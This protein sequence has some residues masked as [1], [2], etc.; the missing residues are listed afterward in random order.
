MIN[1]LGTD[2]MT[3]K[4]ASQRYGYS[5]SWFQKARYMKKSPAY[6]RFRGK[7]KIYYPLKETD[8]WFK[9]NMISLSE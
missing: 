7:G 8:K 4:E 3:D 9:D 1:I 5:V 2:Y 6:V